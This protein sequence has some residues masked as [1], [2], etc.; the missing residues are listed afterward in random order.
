MVFIVRAAAG[1]RWD[2]WFPVVRAVADVVFFKKR[3]FLSTQTGEPTVLWF[4]NP[5]S[6]VPVWGGETHPS[7]RRPPVCE[8]VDRAGTPR[9]ART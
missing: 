2:G 4:G 8:L 9:R 1:V 7:G 3:F 6:L 5:V